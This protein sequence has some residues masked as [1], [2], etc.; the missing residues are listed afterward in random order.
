[1]TRTLPLAALALLATS[2]VLA[3]SARVQVIHNCADA[4]ASVVDVWLDNTLL[5][6]DFAFRTASPFVDAPAG[7][8]FT[9]GIAPSTSTSELESIF[10]Q[11]FT[12]LDGATYVVVASGIVSGTGYAPLTPFTLEVFDQGRESALV[13]SNTDVL[14]L[15]GSTDAP[16]VD[17]FESA[18]LNTTAVDDASY[19]DFAGYL[20]LPTADYSL[21]IR[22]ADNSAIVAA[23]GAPLQTLGLGGAAIT[24]LASG[25][26]DPSVNSNGPSFGLWAATANGG[27]LVELPTAGIP[28]ARVQVIHNSADAAAAEVDVYLNGALLLDD[29]AFRTATPYV[30]LQAG[31]D[32]EVAIA[33][34]TSTSVND[35]IA[36]FPYN[37]AAGETYTLVANGIVS[38]TGY[39]PAQP[40][41]IDVYAGSR[42]TATSGPANTDILVCHGSTDAPVVDVNEVL[43]LGGATLVDD[44]AYGQYQGYVEAPTADYALEINAGGNPVVTY[45]APLATLN[46][47]GAAITVV[48][49]GFLDPS[50]NS[51][52]PAFGLWVA[53]PAGGALVE[54]PEYVAGLT[55]RVQVIHNSADLAASVVDVWLDNT[56]LLDDFA[57]RT[58]SP[59]VDAPAGTQFTVGF[60]PST[61]TSAAESIYTENFTLADGATYVIVASGIVSA[62]G[63]TPLT[64]F[65]LEVFDQARE[66]ADDPA[67]TDLLVFHGS[68]DAPSV[69][70][71]ESGVLNATAV[72][73]A[74][75]GDFAGYLELPTADYTVQVRTADNSTVVAA[76]SAPLQTLGLQD[77]AITVVA[78]GFL[79]P[80]QNSNGPAFGLWVAL[81]AGGPLV[82]LPAAAIPGAR[83]QVIH[84]SADLAAAEVDV[85]LNGA[86][87][88]DDFAFRTATPFVD[89]Q[90]GTD[91]S[92]AIAPSNSTSVADAIATF[93]FNLVTDG[94]YIVVAN[95]IVST[96]GYAPNTPFDLY[97]Y[98]PA[99]ETAT[100]GATNT[101]ILVFHGVTDAPPVDVN[102]TAL[103][104]GATL[105]N[106][107]AYGEFS[108][109]LE[110]PTNDYV[111]QVTDGS[112]PLASYQAPLSTLGLEGDAITVLASGF[113]DPAVNS[114]GPGF[115][116]WVALASGGP[117]VELPVFTSVGDLGIFTGTSVWPNPADQ[118]LNV[119]VPGLGD[120]QVEG[121]LLDATG[122]LVRSFGAGALVRGNDR[123][124]IGTSDLRQGS[125]SFR[126][127]GAD[128]SVVLP[129]NIVH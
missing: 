38:G 55:A 61:S 72:N 110:P 120:V 90:A 33:P 101:D 123:L 80:A 6:D 66:S 58:A 14:V 114:N 36:T 16:T 73:D 50:V 77:D 42:E 126:L 22:A 29:F 63:Y 56:L 49:S 9:V 34:G 35:A 113:L 59:F 67:N 104:G 97:A 71:Y 87:L 11:D 94:K 82:E 76:Y 21:Q 91:L 96:T 54:L 53:L 128:S 62:T 40:F 44:I 57:F 68:T 47:D 99:R 2:P 12:L 18:V 108:S 100:S 32:L 79:D 30:D 129:V 84:N 46:L 3:Q 124:V 17:V 105:V 116:L 125:Y 45:S 69:D 95:G 88:L 109:Y 52:G 92:V 27:A 106:A 28:T 85:Y 10:T 13:G 19:G 98:A 112:T 127:R 24:V 4:A 81:A 74:S 115:G 121:E 48:A 64:P 103:L 39:T 26:L 119:M 122:R 117:L 89:V 51:N 7:T 23:Y 83:L 118:E 70:V 78:S 8:Q 60:A 41:S 86:L 75:Y 15:H 111:L 25:F 31:V 93:P 102:E 107:I 1:M 5:I 43:V 65:S 20:E 37:L